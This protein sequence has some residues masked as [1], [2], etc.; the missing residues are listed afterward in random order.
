MTWVIHCWKARSKTAHLYPDHQH[1]YSLATYLARALK[2]CESMERHP[3]MADR[4]HAT[5]VT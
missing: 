4:R 2:T 3:I 1:H 5:T